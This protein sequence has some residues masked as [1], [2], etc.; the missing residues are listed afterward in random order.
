MLRAD[1]H[2]L[3]LQFNKFIMIDRIWY[4]GQTPNPTSI[5]ASEYDVLLS[6]GI[7]TNSWCCEW[8]LEGLK[9]TM[10]VTASRHTC[11][12]FVHTQ[13]VDTHA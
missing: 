4:G 10:P 7:Q 8:R 1:R 9:A 3:A 13:G 5:T 11:T 12:G 2:A 6:S